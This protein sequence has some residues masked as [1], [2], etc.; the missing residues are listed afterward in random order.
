[1]AGHT[2]VKFSGPN[3]ERKCRDALFFILFIVFWIGMIVVGAQGFANGDPRRLSFGIDSTGNMCGIDNSASASVEVEGTKKDYTDRPVLFYTLTDSNGVVSG[4][5]AD[6]LRVCVKDCP[7]LGPNVSNLGIPANYVADVGGNNCAAAVT[8]AR[9][10]AATLTAIGV[11]SQNCYAQYPTKKFFGFCLPDVSKLDGTVTNVFPKEN[12]DKVTDVYNSGTEQVKR[13][14]ND[15]VVAWWVVLVCAVICCLVCLGWSWVLKKVAGPFIW[16]SVFLAIIMTAAIGGYCLSQSSALQ[17]E[18]DKT[19]GDST[20]AT[21]FQV[22]GA[23]FLVLAVVE[24]CLLC[25]FRKA[26]KMVIKVI[27]ASSDCI[28][29]VN[30]LMFWPL[31][32]FLLIVIL[33][34]WFVMVALWL[35]SAGEVTKS[36]TGLVN[37]TYS[38]E[39][40]GLA[41][42]HFFGMLWTFAFIEG[43]SAITVAGV[44]ASWFF[45]KDK[46]NLE[47]GF[48]MINASLKRCA[49]YHFGSAAVG[50]FL[51]ATVQFIRAVFNYIANNSEKLQENPVGKFLRCC[52][53]CCLSCF[54]RCIKFLNRNAYIQIAINGTSFCEAAK[55]AI[56]MIL[57]NA[58][59]ITALN[60]FGDFFLV[61]GKFFIVGISGLIAAAILFTLRDNGDLE[62]PIFP[63]LITLIVLYAITSAFLGVFEMIVDTIFQCFIID[64][65]KNNGFFAQ[66][67]NLGSF[68]KEE[69]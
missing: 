53:D 39:L 42:Y 35:A 57:T 33:G 44:V 41:A 38:D 55:E 21:I 17:D 11:P 14:W 4:N 62:S 58:R 52:I 45:T 25:F 63:L 7:A 50:S 30:A 2:D 10:T 43:F 29:D 26:I 8:T 60:V 69:E 27:E 68:F 28:R 66:D 54:E 15:L 64:E 59:R 51:L 40:K 65:E 34:V 16:I 1:M 32:P 31:F 47:N 23:I 5:L 48:T 46:K 49:R 37:F 22:V 20:N 3:G 24:L 6:V 36:S 19:G 18:A 9:G 13:L 56:K 67:L 12:L 61:L